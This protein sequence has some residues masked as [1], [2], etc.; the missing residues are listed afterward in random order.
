MGSC[1]G[2]FT[3][4]RQTL[5]LLVSRYFASFHRADSVGHLSFVFMS[6]GTLGT[7]HAGMLGL[8]VAW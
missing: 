1:N 5:H 7:D 6:A 2:H 8:A 4:P 3:G